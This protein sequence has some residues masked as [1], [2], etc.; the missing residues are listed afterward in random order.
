ME[1]AAG[2]V[3]ALNILDCERNTLHTTHTHTR[4]EEP[5]GSQIE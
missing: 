4:P 5:F 1:G 3:E 2:I